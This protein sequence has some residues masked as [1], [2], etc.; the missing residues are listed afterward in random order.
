MMSVICPAVRSIR[1]QKIDPCWVI[2]SAAKVRPMTIPKNFARSPVSIFNAIQVI[3]APP[4]PGRPGLAGRLA[5]RVE[6]RGHAERR[7]GETRDV[8]G[9]VIE[10]EPGERLGADQPLGD[11]PG[12]LVVQALADHAEGQGVDPPVVGLGAEP[13]EDPREPLEPGPDRLAD[14]RPRDARVGLTISR[15]IRAWCQVGPRSATTLL[16]EV[17]DERRSCL[18]RRQRSRTDSGGI[19]AAAPVGLAAPPARRAAPCRRSGS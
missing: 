18:G 6:R 16:E 19:S 3:V 10:V 15:S 4:R 8:V 2:S 7:Q 13:P 1:P 9:Q 11:R 17:A 14:Q 5:R 12:Q